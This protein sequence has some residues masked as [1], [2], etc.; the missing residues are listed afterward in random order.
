[1]NLPK[2]TAQAAAAQRNRAL[3]AALRSPSWGLK[4]PSPSREADG[5]FQRL[6]GRL[7]GWFK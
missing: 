7:L 3:V 6:L 2:A 4:P 5:P 1:M